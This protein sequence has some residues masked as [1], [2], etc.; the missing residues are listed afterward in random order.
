[1]C[2]LLCDSLLYRYQSKVKVLF[3]LTIMLE[4]QL[5]LVHARQQAALDEKS[6]K[7]KGFK[8]GFNK[9]KNSKAL[10]STDQTKEKKPRLLKRYLR[11]GL[12]GS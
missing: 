1:M 5:A 8:L 3:F 2:V 9:M 12:S 11:I 4:S 10:P 7:T 6:K